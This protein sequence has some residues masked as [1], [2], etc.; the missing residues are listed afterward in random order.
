MYRNMRHEFAPE[1]GMSSYHDVDQ[2][3]RASRAEKKL[4]KGVSVLVIGM[5]SAVCWAIVIAL[6]MA[7]SSL[8]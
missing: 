2:V 6:G 1:V 4:P 7:V 8:L 3:S 5:L